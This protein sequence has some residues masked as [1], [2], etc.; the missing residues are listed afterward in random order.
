VTVAPAP[1]LEAGDEL[2]PGLEVIA[3]MARTAAL[4]VYRAWDEARSCQVVVKALRPD[5]RDDEHAAA[6]LRREGGLLLRLA[7]PHIVRAYDVHERS[8]PLVVLECLSGD[9]LDRVLAAD[10]HGLPVGRLATLGGQLCSAVGYLHRAG[11]LHLELRARDVILE[12]SGAKL[13]GLGLALPPGRVVGAVAAPPGRAPEQLRGG[14]LTAAADVW[15]L[16]ALLFEAAAGRPPF[17][18]GAQPPGPA[19][20]LKPL[21]PRLP[22]AVAA[23]I[24]GCLEPEPA[25]RPRLAALAAALEPFA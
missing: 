3:P 9:T 16:G 15:G 18:P 7:H 17:E 25:R 5:R 12:K 8:A 21:R 22:R 2:A 23:V 10:G 11:F 19:P 13:L 1:A 20:A 6:R 24:D 14:E 4:D